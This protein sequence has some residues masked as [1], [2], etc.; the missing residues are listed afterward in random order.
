MSRMPDSWRALRFWRRDID[1]D[2]DEELRFHMESRVEALVTAG[3]S[4]ESA[5]RQA[6]EE[7]GDLA[8]TRARL[9]H[10]DRQRDARLARHL[11]MSAALQDVRFA[12]RVLRRRPGVTA[13][14]TTTMAIG[15][16]AAVSMFGVMRNL[17]LA[18]PP[19]VVAPERVV[20]LYATYPPTGAD[21]GGTSDRWSYPDL[22]S[23][24]AAS[25]TVSSIGG[26]TDG[27]V[28]VGSG[29]SARQVRAGIVT[30]AFW[31][32]LGTRPLHGRFFTAE[33]AHPVSGARLVVVGHAFWLRQFN[34]D[35]AVVG[36][37]LTVKGLPYEI[38]GVAPRG[39][40]GVAFGDMEIWLPA[41]VLDDGEVEPRRRD[42]SSLV[43]RL[44][45]NASTAQANDELTRI[46]NAALEDRYG[47][48]PGRDYPR[49]VRVEAGSIRGAVDA[50]RH[51]TPEARVSLWLFGVGLTLLSVASINVASLLLLRS[52]GRRTEIAVR[53]A[54]GQS[55]SRL[56]AQ[57]LVEGLVLSLLGGVGAL[58]MVS[59]VGGW[60]QRLLL[61]A[62]AWEGA[63]AVDLPM[64]AATA[65]AVLGTSLVAGLAPLS[66]TRLDPV[67]ALREGAIRPST[68]RSIL[69]SSLLVS[70]VALSLVLLVGAG[71]FL[72]SLR[73]VRD[74]DL[75]IDTERVLA[76]R[77]DMTGTGY[78]SAE[79]NAI[80]E[81]GLDQVRALPSI[82]SAALAVSV[83][84]RN[85]RAAGFYLPGRDSM[86]MNPDGSAP[87]G[88]Y[89][90][91][92][93]FATTG[94]RL[95]AG[96][97]FREDE[98]TRADVVIVNETMARRYWPGQNALGQCVQRE[99]A[100][101]CG[102]VVGVAED[103]RL[104]SVAGE[105]A[106]MFFFRPLDPADADERA[107]LVRVDPRRSAQAQAELRRS[108][109]ALQSGTH[110]IDIR[111]LQAALDPQ[112]RPW[113]LGATVFSAFAT[114]SLVL[115]V[116]GLFGSVA[117]AASQRSREIG[118]RLAVGARPRDV[119]RMV[120]AD[121]LKIGTAGVAIG[122]GTAVLVG[123][124]M[125]N[126]L[127]QVS[128]RDPFVLATASVT[129]LAVVF[130]ASLV[131]ALRASRLNPIASLRPD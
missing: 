39:F 113:R 76:V 32:T 106:R 42:R 74:Q 96:R 94:T 15:I 81:R 68:R 21:P 118:V 73:A 60:V 3:L 75:G 117:F 27:N 50:S 84:F 86:V 112:Y 51:W 40:R 124:P 89:V 88:N 6:L 58:A 16:G 2:I 29:P 128:P 55:R 56:G 12:L 114:L 28:V 91:P 41:Y 99:P 17:L 130:A 9:R 23:F 66:A 72:T 31:S 92:D 30:G 4:P 38:V 110:Y 105:P 57:L 52:I 78:S 37:P 14:V 93:Y 61:P 97:A 107:L 48:R 104:F 109:L 43:G 82:Q 79:V 80:Y 1:R 26:Y 120:V 22:E 129:M 70:Q 115:A 33:E 19:H 83:P 62:L 54:L 24:D 53:T 11:W 127:F 20:R 77:L 47:R 102:T 131:P 64:A 103:T 98:R 13:V 119:V 95:V 121:G 108:L 122:L 123:G 34:G 71:L 35:P 46:F 8:E 101:A 59:L 69:H 90:T 125:R 65:V 67:A 36:R 10:T 25:T 7:F 116:V 87:F 126:L 85:A 18:P 100:A 63:M 45:A 5:A 49:D 44:Q 111:S